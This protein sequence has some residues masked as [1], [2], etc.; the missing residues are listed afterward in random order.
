[1]KDYQVHVLLAVGQH[2][3]IITPLHVASQNWT[4]HSLENES[5]K[6]K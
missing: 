4:V 2:D 5:E 3:D 6:G 1:M